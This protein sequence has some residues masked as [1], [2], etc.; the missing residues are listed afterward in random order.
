M[1]VLVEAQGEMLDNIETNVGQAVEYVEQGNEALGQAKSI[2]K[3]TR[4]WACYAIWILLTMVTVIV[5]VVL[6][7]WKDA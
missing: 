5:V 2:Q 7:P 4:K 6:K 3:N 1:A